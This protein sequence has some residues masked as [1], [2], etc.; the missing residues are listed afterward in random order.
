MNTIKNNETGEYWDFIRKQWSNDIQIG[1]LAD[2][3]ECLRE[4]EIEDLHNCTIE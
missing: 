4:I 1:C 3:E 2:R